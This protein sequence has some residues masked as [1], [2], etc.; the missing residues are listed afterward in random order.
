MSTNIRSL[1][2]RLGKMETILNM[3]CNTCKD[4]G[5]SPNQPNPWVLII[6][7]NADPRPYPQSCPDCRRQIYSKVVL[8]ELWEAL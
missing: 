1:E 4:W 5:H 6:E 7:T 2:A 3:G 8:R